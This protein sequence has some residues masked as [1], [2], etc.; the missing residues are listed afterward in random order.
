MQIKHT[1]VIASLALLG[2][3]WSL[4][5]PAY[6]GEVSTIAGSGA[7]GMK[8]GP[9]QQATFI[10]PVGIAVAKDGSIYISDRDAQRIRVLT[11]GGVVKTVA[12]GGE[13]D[14]KRAGLAVPGG[15]KDGPALEARFHGPTGMAFGPDGALYIADLSNSCIRKLWHDQVTT[16]LGVEGTP[17][18]ID[19][20]AKR[21]RLVHPRALTF[22]GAG[23]MY[24]A[25]DGGGLRK[26]DTHGMLKSIHLHDY[27]DPKF[28]LGVAFLADASDPVVAVTSHDGLFIYHPTTGKDEGY[29]AR[30]AFE[31]DLPLGTPNQIVGKDR[32]QFYY[33]DLMM[34]S[35]N[36][37]RL[38]A[39]L[40]AGKLFARAVA[41]SLIRWPW[42]SSGFADGARYD[43]RFYDPMGIALTNNNT[44]IVADTGN[45]R[46]RRME[47]PHTTVSEAGIDPA[48]VVD[49]KHYEVA[50]VGA[51]WTF[52][53]SL[54][55]DSICAAIATTMDRSGRFKK[56]V[57]CHTVR[58][59][60]AIT[61]QDE[62][63]IK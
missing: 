50:L 62:D 15:Y 61:E 54:G 6:A 37:G 29:A 3:A 33:T 51:S 28:A 49:D 41:G 31:G 8:D 40:F 12:G 63:Y 13:I 52:W 30:G 20:D 11:P 26:W 43:S 53:D 21:A 60:A 25:D 46:I 24:I 32:R 2:G 14:A 27:V 44:A 36:Y 57:R 45:R 48:N 42:K 17:G 22:D 35:V 59:D 5:A 4:S 16:V 23:N 10:A 34:S 9:A 55:D 19:G 7:F 18:T 58:I 38:P 56:P 1:L 39:R 47:L